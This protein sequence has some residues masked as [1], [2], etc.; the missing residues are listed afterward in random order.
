MELKLL[1]SE[2]IEKKQLNYLSRF[3][4]INL[5]LL[6]GENLRSM[7]YSGFDGERS[8]PESSTCCHYGGSNFLL[9]G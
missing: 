4:V 9:T 6:T 1:P 8:T 7:S 2:L 5:Q 3:R